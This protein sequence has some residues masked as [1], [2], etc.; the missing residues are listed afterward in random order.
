MRYTLTKVLFFHFPFY[1]DYLIYPT[2][3]LYHKLTRYHSHE[4]NTLIF[5]PDVSIDSVAIFETW[6]HYFPPRKYKP[7]H[8]SF[9]LNP[10]FSG[11]WYV[12]QYCLNRA[13]ACSLT[14]FACNK[15]R[16]STTPTDAVPLQQALSSSQPSHI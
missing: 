2:C 16:P 6:L 8:L 7:L 3:Q 5:F 12:R 15:P 9:L 13:Q 1:N 10:T 14:F 11:W 4:Y